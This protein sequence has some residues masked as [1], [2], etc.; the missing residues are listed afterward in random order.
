MESEEHACLVNNGGVSVSLGKRI[1]R[2]ETAAVVC[3]AVILAFLGE[4]DI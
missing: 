4:M 1:L 3:G 2:A